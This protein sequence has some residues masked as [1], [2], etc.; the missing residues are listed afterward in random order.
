MSTQVAPIEGGC[1]NL[2]TRTRYDK[3]RRDLAQRGGESP[4]KARDRTVED[5]QSRNQ[6]RQQPGYWPGCRVDGGGG[7]SRTHSSTVNTIGVA[8]WFSGF[9]EE[10]EA[11]VVFTMVV[12]GCRWGHGSG[13]GSGRGSGGRWT[14]PGSLEECASGPRSSTSVVPRDDPAVTVST[15]GFSLDGPQGSMTHT[16]TS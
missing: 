9:D 7:G 11:S 5:D 4:S 3:R 16:N 13:R 12:D 8:R 14:Q 1:T 6:T 10:D 15:P 2:A